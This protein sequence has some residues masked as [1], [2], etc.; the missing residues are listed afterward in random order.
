[1]MKGSN[2]PTRSVSSCR[3][4]TVSAATGANKWENKLNETDYR[5]QFNYFVNPT[6]V[7]I[8]MILNPIA[9]SVVA[10]GKPA[11]T[12][13]AA[14]TAKSRILIE[15]VAVIRSPG[16]LMA[17]DPPDGDGVTTIGRDQ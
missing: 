7:D 6:L 5:S 4:D 12:R 13:K 16:E 8:P 17:D 9:G 2:M 14:A 15:S 3:R 1:M 11:S 10:G